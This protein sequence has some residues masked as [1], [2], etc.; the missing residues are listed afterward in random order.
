MTLRL[1]VPKETWTGERRVALDPSV[2]ERFQRLGAEVQIER[3]AGCGSHFGDAQYEK[4]AKLVDDIVAALAAADVTV[5]VQPP[6]LEEVEQLRDGSV[7]IGF[8]A[9]HRNAEVIRRLRDKK[10]TSFAFEL[11]PRISRA[12]S[13]DAL[14]SQAAIAGYKVALMAASLA[15]FFFPM[16]TT[17]AG[18]IRPAKVVVVG[19]G[20]AGLQ[21][22]ATCKRLGAMVEAYDI[23]AAAKEQVESLGAKLIDTGVDAS[24]QGG[25][26]RELTKEEIARQAEV[27]A[28]HIAAASAVITTAAIPG[29]PAPKIV[30]KA[31]VEAMKPG[32]VIVDLAAET[33]GNCELTEPGQTI[34]H[35]DVTIHGPLNV[36]SL[37]PVHASETYAKNVFNFLSPFVKNGELAL[38]WNDEVIARSCL[39]HDGQIRHEPT[40]KLVG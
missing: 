37:I 14:S 1:V 15:S 32:A 10:I 39:T 9:P 35:N 28:R 29:R 20:V 12:Q 36:P 16:L 30:T 4:G 23:R 7:L 38:D 11:L 33:G 13:M 34:E 31:M 27:L 19:A 17:A 25:Y 21:A 22:I 18:T 2:A 8:L 5:R 3:G 26:A 40:R 6:S 24:G